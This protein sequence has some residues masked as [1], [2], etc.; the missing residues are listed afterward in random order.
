[1]KTC[2]IKLSAAA[3]YPMCYTVSGG[4]ETDLTKLTTTGCC[5]ISSAETEIKTID[6]TTCTE[7]ECAW[8]DEKRQC[9][10]VM[11]R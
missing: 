7:S 5:I 9:C 2:P 6:L 10:G 3:F 4:S 8:W 11:D 1:M